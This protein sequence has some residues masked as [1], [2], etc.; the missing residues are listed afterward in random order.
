MDILLYRYRYTDHLPSRVGSKF[1]DHSIGRRSALGELLRR[2][3]S[4]SVNLRSRL[5]SREPVQRLLERSD[6]RL[7][8]V[9]VFGCGLESG[10]IVGRSV[11]GIRVVRVARRRRR[12]AVRS[13]PSVESWSEARHL[14]IETTPKG[15]LEHRLFV[16][17][18]PQLLF[19]VSQVLERTGERT[20]SFP[21]RGVSGSTR[22][23]D[24][25]PIGRRTF[26]R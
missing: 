9:T 13:S 6:G 16:L 1:P 26:S 14:G 22:N 4:R 5:E 17:S 24:R 21:R 23:D 10:S 11:P 18:S 3:P 12:T 15:A 8:V 20:V 2:F 25:D 19:I 7:R